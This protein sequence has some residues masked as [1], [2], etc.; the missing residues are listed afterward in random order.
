MSKDM[1]RN[2]KEKVRV[3]TSLHY[4][5]IVFFMT[6]YVKLPIMCI[7]IEYIALGSMFDILYNDL[8]SYFL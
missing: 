5:N 1:K 3:I 8:L 4:L 2:F 7:V 6:A